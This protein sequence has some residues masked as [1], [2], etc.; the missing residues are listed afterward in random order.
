VRDLH[1]DEGFTLI[2]L[3]VA[4]TLS[5]VVL[6][7]TLD[8]FAGFDRNS[9]A[10]NVKNDSQQDVRAGTDQ[11]ARELRNAVSSG[12]PTPAPLERATAFDLIFQTV[13]RGAIPAG[14]A[15]TSNLKRVRYCLDDST[16]SRGRLIKQTQTWT[17]ASPPV[18]PTSTDPAVTPPCPSAAWN[19]W[20]DPETVADRLVNRNAGQN[21][22]V[23]VFSYTPT[24]ST[25]LTDVTGIQTYLFV[26]R[27]PTK[28]RSTAELTSAVRLRNTN[29]A[30]IATFSVEQQNN[31]V[32]LNASNSRDPEGDSLK[33][34]WSLNGTTIPGATSSRLEYT[35]LASGS[36]HTFT[37]KVTDS[38][39]ASSE[40]TQTVLIQ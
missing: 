15:N 17:S 30:P 1:Q 4:M 9:R 27:E 24:D 10:V 26:N 28:T 14:S 20:G 19:A 23:F 3:L 11:L 35:G 6:G 8:A 2:E 36:S 7:A 38:G 34:Q 12:T 33:Y 25:K 16:P 13:E 32:L 5:L 39:D 40:D 29:R 22:S 37:L 31:H 18:S 21:R